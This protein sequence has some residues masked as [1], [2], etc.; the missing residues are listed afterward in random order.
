ISSL[1]QRYG[2]P[3]TTDFSPDELINAAF[4][5]KKRTGGQITIAEVRQI[6]DCRLTTI[7]MDELYGRYDF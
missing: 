4:A 5:D 6:G 3:T 7:E 1:L 2:L